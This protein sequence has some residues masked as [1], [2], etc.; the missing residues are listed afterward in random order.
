MPCSWTG[1]QV[2]VPDQEAAFEFC[3]METHG[4]AMSTATEVIDTT[5]QRGP[6]R[7]SAWFSCHDRAGFRWWEEGPRWSTHP[8][9]GVHVLCTYVCAHVAHA[10]LLETRED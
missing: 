6:A 10:L 5:W 9:M 1:V 8:H 7:G 3:Y 4:V 2:H